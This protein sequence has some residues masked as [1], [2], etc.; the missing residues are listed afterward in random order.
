M[1]IS[2]FMVTRYVRCLKPNN[3]KASQLFDDELVIQQLQY[4][5]M[6]DIVRIRREVCIYIHTC[7]V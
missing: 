2:V 3:D 1:Y 6:M 7:S 5:G 4:S